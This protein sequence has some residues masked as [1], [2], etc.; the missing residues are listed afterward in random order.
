MITAFQNRFS[1]LYLQIL[2]LCFSKIICYLIININ[3][4]S[5][6]GLGLYIICLTILGLLVIALIIY[7]FELIFP[8]FR[9]PQKIVNHIL[10]K[11]WFYG[12]LPFTAMLLL[13]ALMPLVSLIYGLAKIIFGF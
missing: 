7:I 13:L 5:S 12:L 4:I 1:F 8:N 10:Y 3:R 6:F 2:S 11:I 9:I